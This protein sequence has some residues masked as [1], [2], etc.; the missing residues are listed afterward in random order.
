MLAYYLLPVAPVDIELTPSVRGAAVVV[1]GVQLVA[2]RK[3]R[4]SMKIVTFYFIIIIM[5]IWFGYTP[6]PH[7]T[8]QFQ[9][10]KPLQSLTNYLHQSLC[11][12]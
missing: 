7:R 4:S 9:K 11:S 10:C 12:R 1:G 5:I 8:L 3:V 2:G 6:S